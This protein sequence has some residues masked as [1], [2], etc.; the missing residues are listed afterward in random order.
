MWIANAQAE[1]MLWL[2]TLAHCALCISAPAVSVVVALIVMHI[3]QAVNKH[4]LLDVM[5]LDGLGRN[6]ETTWMT[7][8]A[9]GKK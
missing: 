6:R 8:I 5:H 7:F 1:A 4:S 3:Y 2:M 9:I